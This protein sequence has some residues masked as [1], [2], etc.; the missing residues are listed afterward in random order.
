V[1]L[2]AARR[3]TLVAK[4][5]SKS[6]KARRATPVVELALRAEPQPSAPRRAKKS[7]G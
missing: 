3:W 6:A 4:P 5:V 2:M 7:R 1:L